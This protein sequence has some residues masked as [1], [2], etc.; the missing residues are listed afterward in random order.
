MDETFY[1]Y[2]ADQLLE[3][4]YS[5]VNEDTEIFNVSRISQDIIMV[6]ECYLKCHLSDGR[7]SIYPILTGNTADIEIDELEEDDSMASGGQL[8][9]IGAL[10]RS[11]LP[12]SLPLLSQLLENRIITLRQYISNRLSVTI[13][14]ISS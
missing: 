14:N 3:S 5:I 9:S 13:G 8:L 7:K 4:W 10:G 1:S 6:F 12:H 2:A 11:I